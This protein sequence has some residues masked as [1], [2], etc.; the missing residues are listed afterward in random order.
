[1]KAIVDH[2]Y[3]SSDYVLELPDTDKPVVKD[4]EEMT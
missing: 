2:K 4:S 3:G 1:M